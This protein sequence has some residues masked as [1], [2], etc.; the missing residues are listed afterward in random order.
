MSNDDACVDNCLP[1]RCGDGYIWSGMEECD[2]GNMSLETCPYNEGPCKVCDEDCRLVDGV[3]I[4][5]GDG[6]VQSNEKC[7]DFNM[8]CGTCSSNCQVYESAK[9]TGQ[10]VVLKPSDMLSGDR[11]TLNDGFNPSVT[12]EVS[13]SPTTSLKTIRASAGSIPGNSIPFLGV[14]SATATRM[15]VESIINNPGLPLL[16]KTGN[17]S[18]SVVK[19]EHKRPTSLG[20]EMIEVHVQNTD[21]TVDGMNGGKGGDC[22]S[23]AQCKSNADCRSNLCSPSGTCGCELDV[24]CFNSGFRCQGHVCVPI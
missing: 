9:A 14:D 10:I 11:F 22:S 13:V 12:F 20:N 1:A 18:G 8:Q 16:I 21:F 17:G 4:S 5:C 6:M 19:L 7:D 2:D 3:L 24:D 15:I 23:L